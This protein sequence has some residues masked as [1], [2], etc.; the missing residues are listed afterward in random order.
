MR[1]GQSIIN[2]KAVIHLRL[3]ATAP[4][5]SHYIFERNATKRKIHT[6]YYPLVGSLNFYALKTD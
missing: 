3:I 4:P 5:V 2:E 1:K 6:F